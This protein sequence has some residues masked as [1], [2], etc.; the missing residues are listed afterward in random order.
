MIKLHLLILTLFASIILTACGGGGADASNENTSGA[1]TSEA[2]TS[3][4]NSSEGNSSD[5]NSS[6]GNSSEGNSSEGASVNS[7]PTT[8]VLLSQSRTYPA[9]TSS[10]T[11]HIKITETRLNNDGSKYDLWAYSYSPTKIERRITF[12]GYESNNLPASEGQEFYSVLSEEEIYEY[13]PFPIIPTKNQ[14]KKTIIAYV[15]GEAYLSGIVYDSLEA[16]IFNNE[17]PPKL[18]NSRIKKE[19]ELLQNG[20]QQGTSFCDDK[21][22]STGEIYFSAT[23]SGFWQIGDSVTTTVQNIG[24]V[25]Q[26]DDNDIPSI[27]GSYD[28]T[29]VATNTLTNYHS[30]FRLRGRDFHNVIEFTDRQ[31]TKTSSGEVVLETNSKTYLQ[32]FTGRI[33]ETETSCLGA[34]ND[35]NSLCSSEDNVAT[36]VPTIPEI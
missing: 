9:L 6:D 20:I 33:A 29:T 2:D 36:N 23:G 21:H 22:V 26:C 30:I 31:I 24:P 3:D 32:H 5:G 19:P 13:S 17:I 25:I 14:R 28:L 34:A 7:A 4:G 16:L 18:I 8:K 12:E 35:S 15:G 1:D 10:I 11:Q 27:V